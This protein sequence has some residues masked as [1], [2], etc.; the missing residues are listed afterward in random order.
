MNPTSSKLTLE[1]R[2]QIVDALNA[3]LA[4]ALDLYT[5]IKFAHWNLKGAHFTALHPL[6]DEHAS[7]VLGYADDLAERAVALGGVALGT[8]RVAAS[9]SRLAEYD[10]RL[11]KD[12]DHVKALIPRYDAALDGLRAA[13][14]LADELGDDDTADMITSMT[15]ALEKSAW[16]LHA[17]VG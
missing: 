12:L 17:T 2:R 5:Q 13:R 6:F 4:D 10:L 14:S 9:K 11:V 15:T 1:S 3:S 16:Y 8:A 7:A